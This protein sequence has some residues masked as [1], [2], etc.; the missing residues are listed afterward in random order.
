MSVLLLFSILGTTIVYSA[1]STQLQIQGDAILRS[2]NEIRITGVEFKDSSNGAYETYNSRYTRDT[3]SIFATLPA[4]SSITYTVKVTNKSDRDYVISKIDEISHNTNLTYTSSL[5]VNETE[6]EYPE[7]VDLIVP[8]EFEIV[9]TN[10]TQNTQEE[11]LSL[12]YTFSEVTYKASQLSYENASTSC[13]TI[14]CAL[15]ELST[16]IG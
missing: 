12:Q 10:N 4:N 14:Q 16:L 1:F 6:I 2:D 9:I 3:A 11:T 13:K 7:S 5:K 15:D 8:F